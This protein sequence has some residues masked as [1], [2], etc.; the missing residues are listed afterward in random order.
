MM[1]QLPVKQWGNSHAI[2]LPKSVLEAI[3]VE[4]DDELNV[5]IVN[6]SIVLTKAEKKLTFQEL[7]KDYDGEKFTAELQSLSPEGMKNGKTR[8]YCE[9][10]F[11]PQKSVTGKISLRLRFLGDNL[12]TP[13]DE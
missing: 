2:R 1:L 8:R 5:E 9:N 13:L 12:I 10:Q 4:K 7:F 6:H 3:E 11:R